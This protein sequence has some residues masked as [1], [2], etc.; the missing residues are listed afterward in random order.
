MIICC[1]SLQL[2]VATYVDRVL[3]SEKPACLSVQPPT[4]C[5]AV[6]SPEYSERAWRLP[7]ALLAC[8]A[9]VLD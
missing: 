3:K 6:H 8:I 9:G 4:K 1:R 2:R 5:E 7:P